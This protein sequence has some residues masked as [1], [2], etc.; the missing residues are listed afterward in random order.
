ML[1]LK[2]Q[3]LEGAVRKRTLLSNPNSLT[4]IA[5]LF[6][7]LV[8]G[9]A[10]FVIDKHHKPRGNQV[11]AQAVADT[12]STVEVGN[13]DGST[14]ADGA[15]LPLGHQIGTYIDQNNPGSSIYLEDLSGKTMVRIGE[16][17]AYN[18]KS[19]M[20]VPLV[21]TLYKAAELGRLNLD[22]TIT[23][24]QKDID[25]AYGDLWQKGVG[26]KLT[27]R[28]AARLALEES[29]NTAMRAI[30]DQIFPVMQTY[31]RAYTAIGMDVRIDKNSDTYVSTES[32]S[33]VFRCLY[34]ACYVD[35]QNSDDMLTQ[36]EHTE[37]SAPSTLLPAGT[38][39]SHKIGNIHMGGFNDCGIV[40]AAKKPYLFCIMLAK[41]EPQADADIAQISKMAYDFFEK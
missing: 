36:L 1:L 38:V 34:T 14:S 29:D 13:L 37:F 41:G 16:T 7:V 30:N 17:K 8:V 15:L 25:N 32:Y 23:L 33:K 3:I 26:Y 11:V 20:K 19:L 28:E 2:V 18:I 22:T 21:M 39:V 5:I 10:L 9:S 35:R 31:E 4:A 27:L 6:A 24:Q 12:T 40:F